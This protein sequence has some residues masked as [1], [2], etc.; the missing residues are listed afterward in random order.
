MGLDPGRLA[1]EMH[2]SAMFA[3]TAPEGHGYAECDR[4]RGWWDEHAARAVAAGA[5]V[6]GG[7]AGALP[8]ELALAIHDMS[9][10]PWPRVRPGGRPAERGVQAEGRFLLHRQGR[11]P[12]RCRRPLPPIILTKPRSPAI[13]YASYALAGRRP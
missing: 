8:A 3:C 2:D 7:L 4:A 1:R 10:V 12:D 11:G 5:R 6:T 13:P 9:V